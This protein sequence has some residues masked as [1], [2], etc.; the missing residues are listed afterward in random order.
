M[1]HKIDSIYDLGV[2]EGIKIGK[3]SVKQE[4]YREMLVN[5]ISIRFPQITQATINGILSITDPDM[6]KSIFKVAY[7]ADSQDAFQKN[8]RKLAPVN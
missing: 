4:Y 3:Q 7:S 2:I 6:L 1:N 8:V 5:C